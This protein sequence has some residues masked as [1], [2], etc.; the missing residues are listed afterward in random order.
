MRSQGLG[1]SPAMNQGIYLHN[2]II[3][4]SKLISGPP[5]AAYDIMSRTGAQIAEPIR[6]LQYWQKLMKQRTR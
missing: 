1:L 2:W 3:N 4:A 5:W 6:Q